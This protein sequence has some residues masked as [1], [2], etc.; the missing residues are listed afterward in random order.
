LHGVNRKIFEVERTVLN[1]II[2]MSSV[3]STCAKAKKIAGKRVTVALTRKTMPGFNIFDKKAGKI[4]G[5][6]P[7]RLNLNEFVLLKDTHLPFF[8]SA[9]DAV[10]V[11]R[12]KHGKKMKV[13]IEVETLEQAFN[14]AK[15][16]PDVILLDN[17]SSKQAKS[18]VKKLRSVFKGQIELSGGINLKNLDKFANARSDIISMGCLTYAIKGKN[19]NMKLWAC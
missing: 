12:K 14:A 4:A 11:A 6:W 13:E 2:R 16:K 7:H 9:F 19:F 3:A 5:I 10:V 8:E 15:A 17:F 1:I 18:A